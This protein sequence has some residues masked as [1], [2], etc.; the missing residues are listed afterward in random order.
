MAKILPEK[1][2]NNV[3]VVTG[4]S[5]GL[6]FQLALSLA[7]YY[8]TV[9]CL[10]MFIPVIQNYE[11]INFYKCDISNFEEVKKMKQCINQR[12]G[13]VNIL[14]NNAGITEISE[15]VNVPELRI[16]TVLQVNLIGPCITTQIFLNDILQSKKGA[17][18]NISSVLGIITPA[19]LTSYGASKSGLIC[20]HRC[21]E[22]NLRANLELQRSKNKIKMILVCPGKI[23][24]ELFINVKTPSSLIAPDIDPK[25][26]ANQVVKTLFES[27]LPFVT[28]M[29]PYYSNL[30]PTIMKLNTSYIHILKYLSG[31]NAATKNQK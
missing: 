6:G 15:L 5:G 11:N 21:L 29:M 9:I 28:I 20:F 8:V 1:S 17:I 22:R 7:S 3:A 26:L 14:V 30:I 19:R 16:H 25:K 13:T 18:I 27:P 2:S 10:D 31:M 4:G 23:Q 24:T 12:Y